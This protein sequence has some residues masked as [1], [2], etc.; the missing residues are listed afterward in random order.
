MC[1]LWNTCAKTASK[2]IPQPIRPILCLKI[3]QDMFFL[4]PVLILP[5]TYC[6]VY[7]FMFFNSTKFKA[8][9]KHLLKSKIII[10]IRISYAMSQ[11]QTDFVVDHS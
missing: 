10:L 2:L 11:K 8:N 4:G 7:K 1:R 5:C 9:M 6:L 3:L